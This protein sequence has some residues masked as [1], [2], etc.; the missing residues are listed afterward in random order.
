MIPA[1]LALRTLHTF[2]G[3]PP[4]MALKLP[5]ADVSAATVR[6]FF[7]AEGSVVFSVTQIAPAQW[8]AHVR[9]ASPMAAFGT[10]T[11]FARQHKG[12]EVRLLIG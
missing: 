4:G 6:A 10:A 8:Q 2:F 1:K 5:I 12:H 7:E 3:M 11:K 9:S